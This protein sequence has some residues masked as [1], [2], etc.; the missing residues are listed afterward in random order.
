ML[1]VIY[2]SPVSVFCFDKKLINLALLNLIGNAFK[3]SAGKA[4]PIFYVTQYSESLVFKI[5]DFGI[6]IPPQEQNKLFTSF[7]RA[8]NVSNIS[9]TGLGLIVI[10]FAV[11]KHNGKIL[12]ESKLNEGTIFEITIPKQQ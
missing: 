7:F 2:N 12:I 1:N 8:S 9:G 4:S 11:R 5:Q 10:D 3:Y 6:G